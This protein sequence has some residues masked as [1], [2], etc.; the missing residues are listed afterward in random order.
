VEPA[1]ERLGDKGNFNKSQP[2]LSKKNSQMMS[3]VPIAVEEDDSEEKISMVKS[4]F[5]LHPTSAMHTTIA[6]CKRYAINKHRTECEICIQQHF[7]IA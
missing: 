6:T 1:D 2:S 4:V 7:S 3:R 5:S